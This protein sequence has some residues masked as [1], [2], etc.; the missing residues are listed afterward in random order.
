MLELMWLKGLILKR[1][2]RLIGAA[3]G[4]AI[5]VALLV[6]LGVFISSSAASMT[7]RAI[8][9]VPV[10]W[11]VLLAPGANPQDSAAVVRKTVP[12]TTLEQ[13]GYA[14]AAGFTASS[15]G[16]VQTTGPGKVLGLSPEYQHQF[17]AE[18]R[19]LVGTL[20]GVL[21]AQQTAANLH[22]TV[23][24]AVTIQ[25]IGLSPV[26]VRDRKSVV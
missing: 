13:V 14:D 8:A 3:V 9:D 4:V 21:V 6:S 7:Q 26:T 15:A 20:N 18:F 17:P 11:Q 1:S 19:Q 25:R 5:T 12:V 23:G 10:D 2:T 22:V 16:T 24:D